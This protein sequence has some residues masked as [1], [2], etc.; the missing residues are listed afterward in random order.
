MKPDELLV[1]LA[2]YASTA[3]DF[4]EA[5]RATARLVLADSLGCAALASTHE[6]CRRLLGP[7][8]PG[9]RVPNGARVPATSFELD[10]VKA[11]F[12]IGT[13]IRWLDYNDTWLA[14]EWGH[15]SDNLGAILALADHLDR[16]GTPVS[17]GEILDASIVA[18]EIQGVLALANAFNRVGLDHVL[19]VEVASTAAAGRL[20]GLGEQQL[21]AALSNAWVDGHP[22]RTYRHAPNTGSRKSWA[23]GDATSRGVRLALIARTGEMGYP[24][25]LT[26]EQ[27][28]FEDV[29]FGGRSVTL[30]RPLGTYVMDNILFK[31][32]YP[33]EFHAQ[34]AA[35]AAVLLHGEIVQRLEEIERIEV[36]TQE[37]AIRIIDKRGPLTNPA[38]RDHSL[39]YVIA[40]GL[41]YGTI[42]D[43]HYEDDVA[44]DPRIDV[45]REKMTVVEEPRYTRD[46]LDPA[47]RTIANAIRVVYADG[48]ATD[49]IEV[50]VPLG[51]PRRRA[52][53]QPLLR[54]KLVANL[55]AVWDGRA[56]ELAA[57]LL[58]EPGLPELP[59]AELVGRLTA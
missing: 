41:L 1:E 46:Y 28:G 22:L 37:S 39:Q 43:R 59:A 58:D 52:E 47:K 15:P 38:D 17:V 36:S 13:L 12:D 3:G 32:A 51:H 25:A 7:V 34:T 8:V 18:H 55:G 48:S 44:A 19:L 2:R 53:A 30:A 14:A 33:A 57:L 9:T 6:S 20:L 27:W 5:T 4:P 45:L 16:S 49:R 21:V 24:T 26:A 42:T 40:V 31:V 10:P 56:E 11:A 54:E 35:E 29:R 50:E 23:A